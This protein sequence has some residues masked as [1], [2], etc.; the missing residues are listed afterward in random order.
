MTEPA[1]QEVREPKWKACRRLEAEGRYEAFKKRQAH[2]KRE[3]YRKI[4]KFDKT[5]A[6][7]AALKEFPPKVE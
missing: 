5:E 7:Y 2:H 3:I 1:E 6:F 4:G